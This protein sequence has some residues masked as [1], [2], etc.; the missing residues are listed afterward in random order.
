MAASGV[1]PPKKNTKFDDVDTIQPNCSPF[2][3]LLGRALQEG[4]EIA[5]QR[6]VLA[7][8]AHP[9][10]LRDHPEV[11]LMILK[12]IKP[13]HDLREARQKGMGSELDK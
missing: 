5:L 10:I 1:K 12:Q 3:S 11:F 9:T 7:L 13:H 6:R 4:E 2:S 8:Y